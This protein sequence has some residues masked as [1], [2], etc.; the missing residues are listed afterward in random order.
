MQEGVNPS[1]PTSRVKALTEEL[2]KAAALL[3]PR[4]AEQPLSTFWERSAALPLGRD[5]CRCRKAEFVG[6]DGAGV[7]AS[8]VP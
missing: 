1:F 4:F 3:P 6:S 5:G 8:W 7:R 2:S